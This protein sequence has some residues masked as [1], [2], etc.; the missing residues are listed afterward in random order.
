MEGGRN[1]A[2]GGIEAFP[3]P[4][5]SKNSKTQISPI[6]PYTPCKGCEVCRP[7]GDV[8][9]VSQEASLRSV[10]SS[11]ASKYNN[12]ELLYCFI[13][14]IDIEGLRLYGELRAIRCLVLD[15]WPQSRFKQSPGTHPGQP[16]RDPAAKKSQHA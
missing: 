8:P 13:G 3:E 16:Q 4:L 11:K 15:A 9:P 5:N 6:N 2:E 7:P 10:P 1:E 14:S 12:K